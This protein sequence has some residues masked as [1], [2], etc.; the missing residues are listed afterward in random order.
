MSGGPPG[1]ELVEGVVG[2]RDVAEAEPPQQ[3]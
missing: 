1:L 2:Q 3:L